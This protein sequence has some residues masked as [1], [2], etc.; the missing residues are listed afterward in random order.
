MWDE[1][2]SCDL[3]FLRRKSDLS[4][5]G[6]GIGFLEATIVTVTFDELLLRGLHSVI[7]SLFR[8]EKH[9]KENSSRRSQQKTTPKKEE[10]VECNRKIQTAMYL[11]LDSIFTREKVTRR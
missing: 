9:L 1:R 2:A 10:K 4:Y 11:A 8:Q 6:I 7:L 5:P 3:P